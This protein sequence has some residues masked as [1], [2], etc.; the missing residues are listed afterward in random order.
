MAYIEF[1]NNGTVYALLADNAADER[2]LE[3][4][5]EGGTFR[6]LLDEVKAYLPG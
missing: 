4:A 1:Y 3:V 5:S 2:V 6:H